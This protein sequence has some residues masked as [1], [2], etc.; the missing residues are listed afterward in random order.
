MTRALPVVALVA[1]LGGTAFA[2]TAVGGRDVRDGS[3]TGAD[4]RRATLGS[5]DVRDGSLRAADVQPTALPRA[6][7]GAP[8]PAGVRGAVGP[9]G[10][11]GERGAATPGPAGAAPIV[12]AADDET[13]VP[14]PLAAEAEVMAG[15][16]LVLT[17]PSRVFVRA[18]AELAHDD[19]ADLNVA[20]CHVVFGSQAVTRDLRRTL[21]AGPGR[22]T[23]TVTGAGGFDPGRYSWRLRCSASTGSPSLT[24]ATV[25]VLAVALEDGNDQT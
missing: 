12:A 18:T 13:L 17:V 15:G 20:G 23:L 2:A 25:S 8:G 7:A 22:Q 10:P 3:L 14:R 16:R 21:D 4:L 24:S 19:T 11:R 5:A 6:A 9:A 1:A